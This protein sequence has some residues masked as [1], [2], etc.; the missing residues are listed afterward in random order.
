MLV[1]NVEGWHL[2]QHFPWVS[3]S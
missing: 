2:Y 1:A 3:S